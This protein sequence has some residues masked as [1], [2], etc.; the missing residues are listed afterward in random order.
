MNNA[1][2]HF[3]QQLDTDCTVHTVL[4]KRGK[5]GVVKLLNFSSKTVNNL[6]LNINSIWSAYM[7]GRDL[8][9]PASQFLGELYMLVEYYVT[10]TLKHIITVSIWLG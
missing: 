2:L 9:V 6:N 10:K 8:V 3:L 4:L 1:Y 7:V 5:G